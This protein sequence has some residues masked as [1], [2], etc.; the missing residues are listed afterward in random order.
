VATL[1][2]EDTRLEGDHVYNVVAWRVPKSEVYPEGVKY[3]FH[4]GTIDGQ[5]ILRYDNS[6]GV[7]E[8]HTPAGVSIV[9]FPDLWQHYR[10]FRMEIERL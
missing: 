8:R 10:R 9:D 2:L 7:H 5:T 3:R 4:Y 1:L 6:H